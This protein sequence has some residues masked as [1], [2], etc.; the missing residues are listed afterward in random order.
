[1]K[2]VSLSRSRCI[3]GIRCV[4]KFLPQFRQYKIDANDGQNELIKFKY[5]DTMGVESTRGLTAS[6]FGKIM[7]GHIMDTAEVSCYDL[8]F[9]LQTNSSPAVSKWPDGP[10]L[11]RLQ[12][13]TNGG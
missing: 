2:G 8:Y 13:K 7:D 11:S 4:L 3:N 1:M 12:S 10:R 9:T 5:L 6:D